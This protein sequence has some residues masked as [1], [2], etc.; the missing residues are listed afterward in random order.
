MLGSESLPKDERPVILNDS[1]H[2]PILLGL[3]ERSLS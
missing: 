1:E 3:P 2:Q